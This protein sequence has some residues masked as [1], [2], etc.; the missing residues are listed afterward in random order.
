MWHELICVLDAHVIATAIFRGR[1]IKFLSNCEV[2]LEWWD[3]VQD[4]DI[5]SGAISAEAGKRES[6][7]VAF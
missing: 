5:M 3:N 1:K 7:R 2:W 4:K 6:E